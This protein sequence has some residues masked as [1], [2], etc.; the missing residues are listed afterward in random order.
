MEVIEIAA[1]HTTRG[2]SG[3]NLKL[4]NL[5][6]HPGQVGIK[7]LLWTLCRNDTRTPWALCTMFL[8][9]YLFLF[10]PQTAASQLRRPTLWLWRKHR[11]LLL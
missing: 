5:Y 11:T 8:T 4:G 6:K 9:P 3:Q 7:T 1:V 2:S 10:I